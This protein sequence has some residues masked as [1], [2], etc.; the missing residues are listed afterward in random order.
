ME[1]IF[2][3]KK[4]WSN[5]QNLNHL[6]KLNE[7]I[8]SWKRRYYDSIR[9]SK[10]DL[11]TEE[12]LCVNRWGWSFRQGAEFFPIPGLLEG[13]FIRYPTPIHHTSIFG[14]FPWR[15]EDY[16]TVRERKT[17]RRILVGEYQ[18][19]VNREETTWGWRLNNEFGSYSSLYDSDELISPDVIE[20]LRNHL[21]NLWV[22]GIGDEEEDEWQQPDEFLMNDESDSEEEDHYG[23]NSLGQEE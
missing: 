13:K 21:T 22:A 5:K 3:K 4:K 14:S 2:L 6:L 19:T 17:K 11:I 8:R 7:N 9:D 16:R 1:R 12:E 10:R 15:L 18:L 23:Y 20:A